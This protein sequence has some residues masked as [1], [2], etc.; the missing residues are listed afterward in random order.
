MRRVLCGCG[1]E[2]AVRY[3]F[4]EDGRGGRVYYLFAGCV[5][6]LR[7]RAWVCDC[8]VTDSDLRSIS[9]HVK[10]QLFGK[11]REAFGRC[12][13]H[14]FE[15]GSFDRFES[16]WLQQYAPGCDFDA[17]ARYAH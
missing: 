13:M 1:A 14:R 6:C 10:W 9:T 12:R 2:L 5:K 7:A 11:E 3:S 17:A 8:C 16:A 15:A 4:T